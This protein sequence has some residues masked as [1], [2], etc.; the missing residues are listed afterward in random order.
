M[1]HHR[2]R[3]EHGL[4]LA[5]LEHVDEVANSRHRLLGGVPVDLIVAW[6]ERRNSSYIRGEAARCTLHVGW[7]PMRV[8]REVQTLVGDETFTGVEHRHAAPSQLGQKA[9]KVWVFWPPR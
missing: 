2:L 6:R 9:L 1:H 4:V 5:Q 7:C 8:L 3:L